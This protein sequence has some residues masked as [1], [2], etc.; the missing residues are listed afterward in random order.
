MIVV[1]CKP[2]VALCEKLGFPPKSIQHRAVFGK[3]EVLKRMEESQG[4]RLVLD[5]DPLQGQPPSLRGLPVEDLPQYHLKV[6]RKGQNKVIIFCPRLEEWLLWLARQADV[7]PAQHGLPTEAK[8]LHKVINKRL[9]NLEKFLKDLLTK[10]KSREIL[11][12]LR[13]LLD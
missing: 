6:A 12:V 13:T 11:Q 7:D 4:V 5:E 9:D 3:G 1:E 2:D 10:Q 8:G